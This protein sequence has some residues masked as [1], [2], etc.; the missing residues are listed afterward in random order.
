[1]VGALVVVGMVAFAVVSAILCRIALKKRMK[2]AMV[3]ALA[4]KQMVEIG[5]PS[6]RSV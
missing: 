2:S 1:M 6:E 5:G 3:R 4:H